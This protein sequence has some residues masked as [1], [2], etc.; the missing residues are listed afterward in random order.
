MTP[1]K[2]RRR[3]T[4]LFEVQ[5]HEGG[6]EPLGLRAEKLAQAQAAL[7][8]E[9]KRLCL[10]PHALSPGNALTPLIDGAEAYGAMLAMLT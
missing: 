6:I 10:Q 8:D 9:G 3:G 1:P 7:L 5:S 4:D 2:P